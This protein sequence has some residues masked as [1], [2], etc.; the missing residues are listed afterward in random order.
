[1]QTKIFWVLAAFFFVL[2]KPKSNF[3]KHIQSRFYRVL[4]ILRSQ[5][6]KYTDLRKYTDL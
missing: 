1:M 4:S 5:T 2:V 6:T 3:I